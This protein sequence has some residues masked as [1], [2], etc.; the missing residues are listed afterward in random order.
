MSLSPWMQILT[1]GARSF[2][3]PSVPLSPRREAEASIADRPRRDDF[4]ATLAAAGDSSDEVSRAGERREDDAVLAPR[5]RDRAEVGREPRDRPEVGREPRD[6]SEV[7]AEARAEADIAI[8]AE[9]AR[10]RTGVDEDRDHG[11]A[12]AADAMRAQPA[13]APEPPT[14]P[15]TA[16][17]SA[18]VATPDGDAAR[19]GQMGSGTGS[20][21][22]REAPGVPATPGTSGGRA[23]STSLHVGNAERLA[24]ATAP[25]TSLSAGMARAVTGFATMDAALAGSAAQRPLASGHG[26]E[27]ISPAVASPPM[28]PGSGD[29]VA[30]E[31]GPSASM[32][33]AG[34]S[35]SS[36]LRGLPVGFPGGASGELA[37]D[38]PATATESGP[39]S[40]THGATSDAWRVTTPA[41]SARG[42]QVAMPILAAAAARD[43]TT[44]A[45]PEQVGVPTVS[46]FSSGAEVASA[47]RPSVLGAETSIAAPNDPS[48][49][50][51]LG[52]AASAS[53]V[54]ER[55]V[56]QSPSRATAIPLST[57]G[58][59]GGSPADDGA[60]VPGFDSVPRPATTVPGAERLGAFQRAEGAPA[61]V[62]TMPNF[63]H[64]AS[65]ESAEARPRALSGAA[66]IIA[67]QAGPTDGDNAL[68]PTGQG[69]VPASVSEGGVPPP[70]PSASPS[71]GASTATPGGSI[72]AS[73]G[74]DRPGTGE[75][76]R[77]ASTPGGS[78]DSSAGAAT[79]GT[80]GSADAP[81]RGDTT[82]G[83]LPGGSMAPASGTFLESSPSA[84]SDRDV[85]GG[86]IPP[87]APASP[88]RS[89]AA[90][91][92]DATKGGPHPSA[93]SRVAPKAIEATTTTD[94]SSSSNVAM[95]SGPTVAGSAETFSAAA[96]PSNLAGAGSAT[97]LEEPSQPIRS[98][99]EPA[100]FATAARSSSGSSVA[101]SRATP[102]VLDPGA[103][104]TP[105]D[106][107]TAVPHTL[108]LAV[109]EG[110]REARI[111]LWP[112][113]LGSVR[114]DLRVTGHQVA[115][116]FEAERADV[117]TMLEGM[118]SELSRG[119][120]EAG[121]KL[122]SLDIA[123]AGEG[124]LRGSGGPE[125]RAA[126]GGSF[127]AG[128]SSDGSGSPDRNGSNPMSGDDAWGADGR[129]SGRQGE[130]GGGAPPRVDPASRTAPERAAAD[131]GRSGL[132]GPGQRDT[133]DA[134]A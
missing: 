14:A 69:I 50:A 13:A 60:G 104:V 129:Q 34:R 17:S 83:L 43:A 36:L 46:A 18:E 61:A 54:D 78:S 108:K 26:A 7:A 59:Q 12:L 97:P 32:G 93:S 115:A 51:G 53:A 5:P 20:R 101:A 79:A 132:I 94:V 24:N 45:A 30:S 42:P 39:A 27:T 40:G 37:I 123:P 65:S 81:T 72:L 84:T 86:A 98:S 23:S 100:V 64:G 9:E 11:R 102:R 68:R 82:S 99:G 29:A 66:A 103:P 63:E 127:L 48:M 95:T 75:G 8:A 1:G 107:P 120:Q 122:Q 96:D 3:G 49:K 125:A 114:V 126:G 70:S 15:P 4:A 92:A 19:S 116:R 113:E 134:W 80:T 2:S 71:H 89:G 121:L 22:S 52:G 119:L 76:A 31:R 112:P 90:S 87:G 85:D 128:G 44:S 91:V 6:R 131:R 28:T 35:I 57:S 106:L 25:G 124:T 33:G 109:R 74:A 55:S 10:D 56:D 21:S 38:L 67:S 105:R 77:G 73:A 111:R 117:R 62:L 118:R 133:V 41:G 110:V 47:V 130:N 88:S 16:G 58:P